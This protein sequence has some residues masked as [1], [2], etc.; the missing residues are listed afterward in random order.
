VREGKHHWI[1]G[2][3]SLDCLNK[4]TISSYSLIQYT[5]RLLTVSFELLSLKNKDNIIG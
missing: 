2:V 4:K 1:N 3:T 5:V